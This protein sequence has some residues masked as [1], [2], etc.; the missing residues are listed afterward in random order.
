M[1]T[2]DLVNHSVIMTEDLELNVLKNESAKC[3]PY[4]QIFSV[5]LVK[6]FCMYC[7][8]TVHTTI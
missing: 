2:Y 3:Q 7:L 5:L 6:G 4:S 1:L 8:L